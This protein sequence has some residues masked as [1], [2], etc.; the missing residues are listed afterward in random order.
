MSPTAEPLQ[1]PSAEP[2]NK[3]T[4]APTSEAPKPTDPT[5]AAPSAEPSPG[6]FLP[7]ATTE[8]KREEKVTGNVVESG[9]SAGISASPS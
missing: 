8:P 5:S 9:T 4:S 6:T 3:P 7:A 1:R 2:S